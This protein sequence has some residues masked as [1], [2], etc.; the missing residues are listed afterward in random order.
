[1]DSDWPRVIPGNT[2]MRYAVAAGSTGQIE[3][4]DGMRDTWPPLPHEGDILN[5]PFLVRPGTRD[6]VPVR[7][8]QIL[9]MLHMTPPTIAIVVG[10]AH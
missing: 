5:V 10:L 6:P 9:E 2:V 8:V 3:Q 7:V 1:M 4:L